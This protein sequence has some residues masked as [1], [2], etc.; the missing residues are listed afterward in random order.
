MLRLG[1]GLAV[2]CRLCFRFVLLRGVVD[3]PAIGSWF[4]AQP[5]MSTETGWKR[6]EIRSGRRKGEDKENRMHRGGEYSQSPGFANPGITNLLWAADS[7][8]T[9]EFLPGC[10][11][12]GSSGVAEVFVDRKE[13]CQRA[14]GV[15][16]KEKTACTVSRQKEE[17]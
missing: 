3:A 1:L 12:W 8:A 11:S 17:K 14:T 16:R 9:Q 13:D 4:L 5:P 6:R 7:P 15:N 2:S 10:V